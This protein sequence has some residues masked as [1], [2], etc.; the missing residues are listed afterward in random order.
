MTS[1]F[2]EENITSVVRSH[3][4]CQHMKRVYSFTSLSCHPLLRWPYWTAASVYGHCWC[5]HDWTGPWS[6]QS[7]C[8]S[9]VNLGGEYT[10]QHGSRTFRRWNASRYL[11][12]PSSLWIRCIF[13]SWIILLCVVASAAPFPQ[14]V[15]VLFSTSVATCRE[16][17]WIMDKWNVLIWPAIQ[18]SVRVKW[19]INMSVSGC[20]WIS[21]V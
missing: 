3:T 20:V 6:M 7:S 14:V 10:V 9:L 17:P 1:G 11:F 15:C 19:K 4:E 13:V 18:S 21:C 16:K 5:L 8:Q 12:R 2:S